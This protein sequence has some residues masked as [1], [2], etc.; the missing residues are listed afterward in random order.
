MYPVRNRGR[1][2][3]S[4]L[5][6]RGYAK[7]IDEARYPVMKHINSYSQEYGRGIIERDGQIFD[8]LGIND[9]DKQRILAENLRRFVGNT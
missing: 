9:K 6:A 3:Y 5:I 7:S 4:Y 8:D 1:K 2:V